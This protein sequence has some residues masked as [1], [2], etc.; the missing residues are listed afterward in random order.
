MV[1]ILDVRTG[2][3]RAAADCDAARGHGVIRLL[4]IGAEVGVDEIVILDLCRRRARADCRDTV[5]RLNDLLNC[6]VRVEV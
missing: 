4:G 5:G 2:T 6:P 3:G 1:H